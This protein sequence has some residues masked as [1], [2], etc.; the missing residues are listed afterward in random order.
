MSDTY[1]M[2]IPVEMGHTAQLCQVQ[3]NAVSRESTELPI[4][5]F[6][7]AEICCITGLSRAILLLVRGLLSIKRTQ[8]TIFSDKLFYKKL[9]HGL[10][11]NTYAECQM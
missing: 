5:T 4:P 8:S 10:F 9:S 3:M 7:Q 6:L 11:P 1:Q 2:C